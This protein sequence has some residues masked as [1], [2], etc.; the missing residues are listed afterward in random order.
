MTTHQRR[1]Y[2]TMRDSK[3]G[4]TKPDAGSVSGSLEGAVLSGAHEPTHDEIQLRAHEI[5]MKRGSGDGN[6]LDDWLQAELELRADLP[7]GSEQDG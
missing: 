2:S 5:H 6:D 3:K 4:T 7:K 1:A